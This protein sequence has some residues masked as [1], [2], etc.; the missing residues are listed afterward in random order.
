VFFNVVVLIGMDADY[1]MN[2]DPVRPNSSTS[3]LAQIIVV[4][5]KASSLLEDSMS[6]LKIR[7]V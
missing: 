5:S 3:S 7:A 4:E 1:S 2:S 6:T